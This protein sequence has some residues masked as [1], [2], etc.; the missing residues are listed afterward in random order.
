[1]ADV[2]TAVKVGVVTLGSLLSGGHKKQQAAVPPPSSVT[3]T[4]PT[5]KPCRTDPYV[6]KYQT[7][8]TPPSAGDTTDGKTAGISNTDLAKIAAR[9]E[10]G[11]PCDMNPPPPPP[12]PKPCATSTN[13]PPK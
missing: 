8:L 12:P 2:A 6:A 7:L 11:V 1:M 3:V 13:C 5:I 10:D 4:A 9:A